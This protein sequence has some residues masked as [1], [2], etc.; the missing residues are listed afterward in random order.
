MIDMYPMVLGVMEKINEWND[1][2][3]GFASEHLDN[4]WSG[5]AILAVIILVAFWAISALN[6]K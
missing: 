3:N 4:V 1:K 6:K 2:L 5:V